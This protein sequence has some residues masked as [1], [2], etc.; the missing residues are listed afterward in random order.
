MTKRK[1]RR[2]RNSKLVPLLVILLLI[3]VV[4]AVGMITSLIKKYTPSDVRMELE[5]YYQIPL[6]DEVVLILQDSVSETR[7]RLSEGVVYLPYQ[8]VTETLGGR[9]YWDQASQKM[10][11]TTPDE[12]L[13]IIPGSSIPTLP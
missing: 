1:R 10:L 2:R 5:D 9:F 3:I 4:S 7:G 6:E 13:E 11:Y 8:T 12:I